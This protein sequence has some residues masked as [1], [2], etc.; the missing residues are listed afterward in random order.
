MRTIV[1]VDVKCDIPY[2]DPPVPLWTLRG[3]KEVAL[4]LTP[5]P[6]MTLIVDGVD[7]RVEQV[8]FCVD[9][10]TLWVGCDTIQTT[11]ADID[12]VKNAWKR[13]GWTVYRTNLAT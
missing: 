4:P 12:A 7:M 2:A 13:L 8:S 6:G 3:E 5:F 1:S 11:S 10:Q 9:N